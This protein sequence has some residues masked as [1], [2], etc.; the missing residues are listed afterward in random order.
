MTKRTSMAG[1]SLRDL[2]YIQSIAKEGHFGRAASICGVSQPA[3][4]Q[5]VLKLEA[6]LG[7]SIFERQGKHVSLT[8]NGQIVFRKVEILLAEARELL[9]LSLGLNNSLE[10]K[11]RIGVIPTLGPYLLPLVLKSIKSAYPNVQISLFEEPTQILEVMLTKRE[12]DLA[13]VA[14]EPKQQMLVSLTLFFEDFIFACPKEHK[15]N[16]GLPVRW[17]EV[18]ASKLVLL[19]EEHCLRDQTIA[20]CDRV[21]LPE[22]RVA[23]SLEMLRHMVAL[24]EGAALF[25]ALSVSGPD[26]FGGL[27][28]LHPIDGGN[29]GRYIRLAWRNSDPR[30]E[31]LE[32]FGK[33]LRSQME[34]PSM[35]KL[36]KGR[37]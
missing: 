37:C 29:F 3:I 32:Q 13:L 28:T 24:G 4:S 27:T 31:H 5:Q 1:L 23:S 14:T 36:Y 9:E 35:A 34:M 7:F 16:P 8:P 15:E 2:E 21:N 25:P 19:S 11:L 20:L 33:F 22:N 30:A 6:R 12:L 17:S 18:L 26:R 10:G